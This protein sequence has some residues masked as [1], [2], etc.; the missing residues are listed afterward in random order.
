MN[1]NGNAIIK[2]TIFVVFLIAAM[3]LGDLVLAG[4]MHRPLEQVPNVLKFIAHGIMLAIL[5]VAVKKY[6]AK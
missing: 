3:Y 1:I 4:I 5:F 2:V 6:F